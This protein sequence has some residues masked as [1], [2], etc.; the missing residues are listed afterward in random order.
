MVVEP[1]ENP[2]FSTKNKNTAGGISKNES[3]DGFSGGV[4]AGLPAQAAGLS[5]SHFAQS[6]FGQTGKTVIVLVVMAFLLGP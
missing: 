5:F 3:K 6:R 4:S 2:T 1:P